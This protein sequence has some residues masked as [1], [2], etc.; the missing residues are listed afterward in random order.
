MGGRGGPGPDPGGGGCLQMRLPGEMLQLLA[1]GASVSFS[2]T[3]SATLRM[4]NHTSQCKIVDNS[5]RV[6]AYV[7]VVGEP[8][9]LALLGRVGYTMSRMTTSL[10]V[11]QSRK[12]KAATVAAS[13]SASTSKAATLSVAETEASGTRK[14]RRSTNAA[15]TDSIRKRERAALAARYGGRAAKRARG[16]S[17]R[18]T[19]LAGT[20]PHLREEVIRLLM[21]KPMTLS[22][23]KSQLDVTP[24]QAKVLVSILSE[25]ASPHPKSPSHYV[26][27]SSVGTAAGGPVDVDAIVDA[28]NRSPSRAAA[29]IRPVL[30]STRRTTLSPVPSASNPP[31][32]LTPTAHAARSLAFVSRIDE[33][34]SKL[35]ITV[36]PFPSAQTMLVLGKLPPADAIAA[37][38]QQYPPITDRPQYRRYKNLF[39]E[40]YAKYRAIDADLSANTALFKSLGERVDEPE[41]IELIQELANVRTDVRKSLYAY[42]GRLQ[43]E[44][45]AIKAHVVAY[46]DGEAKLAS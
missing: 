41:A 2:G 13:K 7:P 18:T 20:R 44:L 9:S 34:A 37:D 14:R 42:F 16:L 11:A 39:N 3:D 38:E 40:L 23:L 31:P 43:R 26:L 21:A 5:A 28:N 45:E 33:L 27:S 24:T 32:L 22:K 15:K 17:G 25:I 12:Y 35:G 8:F 29:G 6:E 10:S 46:V 36:A 4:G 30:P 1:K 19:G